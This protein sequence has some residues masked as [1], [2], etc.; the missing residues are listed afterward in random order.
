MFD[1]NQFQSLLNTMQEQ[2]KEL[3]SSAQ[4]SIHTAKS[5]GGLVSV[6]INGAG[7]VLDIS[8]DDSLL[9]DKDSLQILLI[10]AINDAYKN[11]ENNKK[12]QALNLLGGLSPFNK[13]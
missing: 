9:E 10:S 6:S 5:G 12:S 1:M 8:I 11:V 4:D 2:I 13:S 3:E 7:E